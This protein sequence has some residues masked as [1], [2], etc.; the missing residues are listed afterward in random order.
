[1]PNIHDYDETNA[2]DFAMEMGLACV[3]CRCLLIIKWNEMK[4]WVSLLF[5]H[6]SGMWIQFLFLQRASWYEILFT[7]LFL[8]LRFSEL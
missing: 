2:D 8:R 4:L 6:F 3:V 1:M 5:A 7:Q